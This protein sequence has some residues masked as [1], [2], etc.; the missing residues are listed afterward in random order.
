MSFNPDPME[1]RIHQPASSLMVTHL[2]TQPLQVLHQQYG[3]TF[4]QALQE[5]GSEETITTLENGLPLDDMV[6]PAEAYLDLFGAT[7]QHA[8]IQATYGITRDR[9]TLLEASL[10]LRDRAQQT[11]NRLLISR[12]IDAAYDIRLQ[13]LNPD[14]S[15]VVPYREDLDDSEIQLHVSIAGY[16]LDCLLW[17]TGMAHEEAELL[18]P[19]F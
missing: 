10:E 13:R 5:H 19:G 3:D 1:M 15:P 18:L 8:D 4:E 16:A 12:E 2:P 14:G 9:R 6:H 7:M 11:R 17:Q